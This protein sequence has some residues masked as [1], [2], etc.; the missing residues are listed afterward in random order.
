QGGC[1]KAKIHYK[2][3]E[4]NFLRYCQ[5]LDVTDILPDVKQKAS[6]LQEL[7]K[8]EQSIREE[9]RSLQSKI[10]R[11][12]ETMG[13]ISD[14]DT[15][16]TLANTIS[17]HND[18]IK[19]FMVEQ[20]FIENT[21]KSEESAP[22]ATE[23]QLKNITELIVRMNELEVNDEKRISIRTS[24]RAHIMRLVDKIKVNL[25][26]QTITIFFRTGQR[27]ALRLNKDG[28]TFLID[29]FPKPAGFVK[30]EEGYVKM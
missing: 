14:R 6:T 12:T 24:L 9:I 15:R 2:M 30:T 5:G 27:R 16:K 4:D 21:I 11:L 23:E 13:D 26:G 7:H 10:D 3:F 18:L 8:R 25:D 29:A 1:T 20:K 19:S 22:K 28:G 17:K